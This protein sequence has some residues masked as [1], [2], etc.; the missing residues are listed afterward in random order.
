MVAAAGNSGNWAPFHLHSR[1][2]LA[3]PPSLGLSSAAFTVPYSLKL[4]ADLADFDSLQF[5]LGADE[6]SGF[7]FRGQTPFD[8]ISNRLNTVVTDTLK[9]ISGNR[10]GIVVQTWAEKKNGRYRLQVY[11]PNPDSSNYLFRFITPKA[12]VPSTFGRRPIF[13][14][15]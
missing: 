4:W 15:E 5:S 14:N 13:G 10:L 7:N 12:P 6:P 1:A 11:I 2:E 8:D 9:S 3:T